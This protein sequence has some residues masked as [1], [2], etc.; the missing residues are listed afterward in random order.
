MAASVARSTSEEC[1]PTQNRQLLIRCIA[2]SRPIDSHAQIYI[3]KEMWIDACCQATRSL[4][5]VGPPE[6]IMICCPIENR[7][8]ALKSIVLTMASE[9]EPVGVA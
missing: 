7:D 5:L 6:L 1:A 3:Q 8:V 9:R 4:N 2:K